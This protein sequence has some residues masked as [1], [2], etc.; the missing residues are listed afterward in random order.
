MTEI[1]L[2]EWCY[3]QGVANGVTPHA[4][5]YRWIRGKYPGLKVRR[6]NQRVVYVQVNGEPYCR[7]CGQT[8][9]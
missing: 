5:Y 2:K 7:C 9:K 6:V 4:I 3:E 8:I 1:P